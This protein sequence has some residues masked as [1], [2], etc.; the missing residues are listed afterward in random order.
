MSAY[1]FGLSVEILKCGGVS[2]SL[3]KYHIALV[4]HDRKPTE[5]FGY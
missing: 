2:F 1:S 5:A 4:V 3:T